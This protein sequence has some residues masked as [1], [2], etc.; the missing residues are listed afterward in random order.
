MK[1]I[2]V[3][4]LVFLCTFSYSQTSGEEWTPKPFDLIVSGN[5]SPEPAKFLLIC[6]NKHFNKERYSREFVAKNRLDTIS[7]KKMMT[8]QVFVPGNDSKVTDLT[9]DAMEEN[10]REIQIYYSYKGLLSQNERGGAFVIAQTAK[11]KKP[12]VFFENGQ[13]IR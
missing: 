8:V 2:L 3:P 11:S 10:Q 9:I 13:K 12:V 5:E 1:F 7:Y 6:Y 4:I